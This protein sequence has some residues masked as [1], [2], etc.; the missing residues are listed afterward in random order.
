MSWQAILYFSLLLSISAPDVQECGG[1][2]SAQLHP[3][4]LGFQ[5]QQ[6][7][8]GPV[9]GSEDVYYIAA[10]GRFDGCAA[11]LGFSRSSNSATYY[12]LDDGERCSL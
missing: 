10:R 1:T 12:S 4:N 2:A 8:I 5:Q 9:Q 11:L 6:W 7:S 3:P